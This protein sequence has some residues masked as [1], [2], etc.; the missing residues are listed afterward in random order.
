MKIDHRAAAVVAIAL[1]AALA[2]GASGQD[3]APAG[4]RSGVLNVRD[5][6]DPARNPWMAEINQEIIKIQE[7]DAGRATDLNPQ[8]RK[9][10]Y[11]KNLDHLNKRRLELYAAVVRH[12]GEVAKERGYDFVQRVDPMPTTTSGDADLLERIYS[13]DL[14]YQAPGTDITNDVLDRLQKEHA[15]RKK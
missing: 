6:M 5:C 1:V 3:K 2:I 11:T 8:E 12:A 13:R 10:I 4:A 9:R 7:A 15:G 14:V